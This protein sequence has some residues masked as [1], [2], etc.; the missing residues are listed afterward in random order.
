ME[1]VIRDMLVSYV[2]VYIFI[3]RSMQPV[4]LLWKLIALRE[5]GIFHVD[6]CHRSAGRHAPSL[7]PYLDL[8]WNCWHVRGNGRRSSS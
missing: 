7:L 1:E 6:L 8:E 3:G 4:A 2:T 5:K